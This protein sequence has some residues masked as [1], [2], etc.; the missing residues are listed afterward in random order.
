MDSFATF[1]VFLSYLCL[2]LVI[3]SY[4]CFRKTQNASTNRIKTHK[5]LQK[6]PYFNSAIKN[7]SANFEW[8]DLFQAANGQIMNDTSK[9]YDRN[10]L[11]D[12][13]GLQELRWKF[14]GGGTASMSLNVCEHFHYLTLERRH[15]NTR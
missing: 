5:R 2:R 7:K 8:K 9:G 11:G 6:N 13:H 3:L 12:L 14:G 15:I 10:K 4:L 1:C